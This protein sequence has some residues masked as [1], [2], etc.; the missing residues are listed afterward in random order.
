[1]KKTLLVSS[2][3]LLLFSINSTAQNWLTAGNSLSANG[4]LGSTTNFSVLFKS[5]NSERGR[6][7]NSGLWGFGTTAP[8]S[9]VHINS[10][11]GQIPLRVQINAST[12]FL[13]NSSGNV[14]VGTTSPHAKLDV[15]GPVLGFD[16]YF[17][18]RFPT[19]VGTSGA[20]Y[21][22]VGY[23][24][25]FT[26]T[27]AIYRYRINSDYSSM[28]SFRS[29]G[30]DFNTAPIGT[31]GA[32]IPYT[33]AMAILQNGNV[34]I[35]TLTPANKLSVA[36]TGDFLRLKASGTSDFAQVN[37]SVLNV[38]SSGS[39]AA[40]IENTGN[41]NSS[42]GLQITAGS[43]TGNG[44]YFTFFYRP[45]ITFCG[46][47]FQVGG[48]GVSYGSA[49]DKRLKNI[50]GTTQK[51]LSDLMKIK[52]YDYTFKRDPQK[53]VLTGFMAQE[54]Y[55]IFPQSVSKPGDNNEPAEKNPWMVDY[56]SVTPL[57]IKSVQEQQ[58]IIDKLK[59]SNDDL[60]KQNENLEERILKLETAM[61]SLT[62][63][64]GNVSDVIANASLEQNNPNP[65]T[66][67]TIIR[68]SIPQGS[69]AQINIYDQSGKMV[70]MLNA[71]AGGQSQVS[72][73]DLAAGAY[74]YTLM[75][76][77]KLALSKQMLIIR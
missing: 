45:D 11:S 59:E 50:I 18:K 29:G 42:H 1:M 48:N 39:V 6:L 23:G 47:I 57:I 75:I 62:A 21:S 3:S 38:I 60:K 27:T 10:A 2:L 43:N 8:N 7:T 52:I 19:S 66:K 5:N 54:L 67:N 24:L 17:G 55:D 35:G 13:V 9:K 36:G 63:N 68:Y 58:Q 77:G 33:T 46:G 65:F 72:G 26:D 61:Q 32:I 53:M 41:T 56:G 76:N 44:A 40:H 34:G 22:S 70:K 15:A 30:F 51:G 74:T 20:S 71:N 25:T 64:N 4:T 14:G 16:S 37:M 69:K 31:A 12:K 73:H 28:L 49:S